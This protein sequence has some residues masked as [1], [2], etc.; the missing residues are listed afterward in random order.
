MYTKTSTR[1]YNMSVVP[2]PDETHEHTETTQYR[3]VCRDLYTN[4]L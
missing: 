4:S 2:N 3:L 1:D